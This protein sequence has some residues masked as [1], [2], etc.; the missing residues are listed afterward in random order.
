MG[1]TILRWTS[2]FIYLFAEKDILLIFLVLLQ[3]Y[4]LSK[5]QIR[6]IIW[7]K[8]GYAIAVP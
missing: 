2:G 8:L 7:S 1:K 5:H 3:N 4:L 6:E